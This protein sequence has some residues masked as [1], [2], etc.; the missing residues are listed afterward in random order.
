MKKTIACL[1]V[2][3]LLGGCADLQRGALNPDTLRAAGEA[4]GTL[5][6]SDATPEQ[7][8]QIGRE[9]ASMLLGAAPLVQDK[10]ILQYVNA[11][12][13]WIARQ[14]GRNDINWRF[15]VIN[16][17]NVNAFAA[18]DGYI[19]I[20]KGLLRQLNNEAE[21][22]GVIAHELTHVTKRHY[23]IAMK[24]KDTLGAFAKVGEST[25]AKSGIRG[26]DMAATPMFNLAQNMYSSGLD[27][28]DE[29]EADRMGIVYAT[30]A[31]YDPYGLPRVLAMYAAN[32]GAPGF[33]LLFS[34]HPSPQDRMAELNKAVG[35]KLAAYEANSV[36][37]NPA[38]AK[39]VARAKAIPDP[40]PRR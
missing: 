17:S 5:A 22:A 31:G 18:P 16:S 14:T 27:K 7:E 11:L 36:V 39:I 25:V 26:G 8:A 2:L 29:Y 9:S 3:G 1:A 34:T 38:F 4:V 12:G 23:L 21:L 33:D 20:T 6:K 37:D 19:L 24:K 40:A 30:R 13:S 15:G 32:T 28:G 10:E 35:D